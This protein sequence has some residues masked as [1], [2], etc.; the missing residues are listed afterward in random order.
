MNKKIYITLILGMFLISLVAAESI[1]DFKQNE[2][3]QIT[4]YCKVASCTYMNLT[5]LTLPNNTIL[6][7]NTLMTKDGQNFNY[8]YTPI[9]LGTYTFNTCGNPGGELIC[10]SDTFLVTPS[11]KSGADNMVFFIVVILLLYG[12]SITGF[13]NENAIMAIF[14]GMALIFLGIYM[15]QNGIVIYRDNL[16]NYISYITIGWGAFSS[17]FAIWKEWLE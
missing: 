10:D 3:M 1:G 15:I 16:T 2:K 14:G 6:N 4:N 12:L 13:L 8:S 17:L 7:I 5:S 9:E 11:G